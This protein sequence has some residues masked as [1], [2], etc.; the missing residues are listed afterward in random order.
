MA[1]KTIDINAALYDTSTCSN[2]PDTWE[3]TINDKELRTKA[4]G[5]IL[6]EDECDNCGKTLKCA[7][8]SD[9]GYDSAMLCSECLNAIAKELEE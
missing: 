5:F 9:S 7:A 2:F 4:G 1:P 8:I 6:K 3:T